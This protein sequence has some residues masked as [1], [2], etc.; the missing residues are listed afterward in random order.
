MKNLINNVK[1]VN[2]WSALGLI[3][4]AALFGS[5]VFCIAV[6]QGDC[7]VHFVLQ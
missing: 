6:S 5:I 4:I 1:Q 3:V 2:V 7:I